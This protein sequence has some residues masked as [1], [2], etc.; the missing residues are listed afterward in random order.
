MGI[1]LPVRRHHHHWGDEP[2]TP[3]VQL[4]F[5]PVLEGLNLMTLKRIGKAI[6]AFLWL[7]EAERQSKINAQFERIYQDIEKLRKAY[8]ALTSAKWQCRE[9]G[10]PDII[11]DWTCPRCGSKK[12]WQTGQKGGIYLAK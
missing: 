1:L 11:N 5:R 3:M 6:A 2:A 8:E 7:N 9:C 4:V 12:Q 10:R